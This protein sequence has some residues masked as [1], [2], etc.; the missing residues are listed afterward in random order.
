MRFALPALLVLPL[1]LLASSARAGEFDMIPVLGLNWHN[2]S[3]NPEPP[4]STFKAAS[5][6]DFGILAVKDLRGPY[7]FEFGVLRH[8]RGY[9]QANAVGAVQTRY[10]GWMIPTT[11]RFMRADFFG[12]GFGPYFAYFGSSN[13]VT[14]IA[15]GTST[16]SAVGVGRRRLDIGLRASLHVELPM[17]ADFQELGNS[18]F[19]LDLS[20]LFGFTDLN[21]SP[22]AEDKNQEFLA[23]IGLRIPLSE[24]TPPIL[25]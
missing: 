6:F 25:Q 1:V 22:A 13:D 19:T 18:R 15:G 5:R 24:E 17:P 20:Y 11:L 3:M 7:E 8:N 12:I 14:T 2:P 16:T 9:D 4:G 21:G 10:G 23:L